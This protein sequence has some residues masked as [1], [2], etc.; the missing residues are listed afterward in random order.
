M[1]YL[2]AHYC[3]VFQHSDLHGRS[4]KRWYC[5]IAHTLALEGQLT[6]RSGECQ[7]SESIVV[8]ADVSLRSLPTQYWLCFVVY[9]VVFWGELN[10]TSAGFQALES[11]PARR[12]GQ[13]EGRRCAAML[14][15]ERSRGRDLLNY[16]T[17]SRWHELQRTTQSCAGFHRLEAPASKHLRKSDTVDMIC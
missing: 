3:S 11:A 4:T 7:A 10:S 17:Y 16:D 12:R 5:F 6:D 13:R 8:V 14:L 2:R 1:V 9:M 15:Q